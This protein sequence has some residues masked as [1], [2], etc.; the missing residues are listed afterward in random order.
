MKQKYLWVAIDIDRQLKELRNQVKLV[1]D[2][3]GSSNTALTLPLHISLRISFPVEDSVFEE[4][5]RRIGGYYAGLSP[6]E[7]EVQGIERNG[8]I[9]WLKMKGNEQLDRIHADLVEIFQKEYGVP[10]HTYDRAFLYHATLW[11][12]K[13]EAQAEEAYECLKQE[14]L[15]GRLVAEKFVIGCSETGRAGEFRVIQE[16]FGQHADGFSDAE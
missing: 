5:V 10:P 12:G 7:V 16:Q 15:P 4:A 6:F 1:A 3:L 11:M 9:V 14:K 2:R 8:N 13:D